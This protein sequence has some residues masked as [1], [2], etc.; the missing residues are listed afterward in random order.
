MYENIDTNSG[1]QL[2]S[3]AKT[4]IFRPSLITVFEA[5]ASS[6]DEFID[7]LRSTTRTSKTT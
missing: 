5:R 4:L 2:I 1:Q 7:R 3:L 6:P